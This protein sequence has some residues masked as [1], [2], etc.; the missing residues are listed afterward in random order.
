MFACSE[1]SL[2]FGKTSNDQSTKRLVSALQGIESL[3]LFALD[4]SLRTASRGSSDI[5]IFGRE[6]VSFGSRSLIAARRSRFP[7]DR[8]RMSE[9]RGLRA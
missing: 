1:S 2:P 9:R 8:N 3:H 4:W 6:S 7:P 5:V